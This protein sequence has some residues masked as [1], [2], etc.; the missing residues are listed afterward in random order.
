VALCGRTGWAAA[1]LAVL[2]RGFRSPRA[3]VEAQRVPQVPYGAGA[4]AAVAGA[5]AMIDVSDGLVGDLGHVAAAS[6]VVIDLH[7]HAFEVPDPLQAVAAATGADPY[8]LLLTGGEDHALAA[9]GNVAA[10]VPDGWRVVGAVSEP[11]GQQPA[12]VLVDGVGW[13]AE[14]G[15]EHFGQRP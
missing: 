2:Q 13:T 15:Y 7:R 4:R 6:G 8:V 14:G 10:A 11:A 12:A 3:V 5:T 9:S 1:G